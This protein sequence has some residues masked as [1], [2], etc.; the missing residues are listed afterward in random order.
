MNR[1]HFIK[2]FTKAAVA[3]TVLNGL[4]VTA[5]GK[6]NAILQKLAR[7]TAD[8]GRVLVMIE[9][10]GGN[11]G[12][13]TVVPIDQYANLS[14]AR[15]NLLIPENQ[16]LSLNGLAA[17]K[18]HPAMP[19]MSSL[20]NQELVNIVQGVGYPNPDYSHFRSTD[21]WLTGVSSDVY[22]D[23]GWMARYLDGLYPGF[24]QNYPNADMPDPLAIQ[25]GDAPSAALQGPVMNM[26]MAIL[27]PSIIYQFTTGTVDPA[28]ATPAGNE[29][30][31]IRFVAQQSQQYFQ[32]VR[33]AAL[34]ATN[35]STLYPPEGENK[36]A[37]ELKVVARLIAGG[38]KTPVY[39]TGL[40]GFD[41][42]SNQ[43]NVTGGST[44][45][46]H[47][48]LLRKVSQAIAAFQDDIHLL[49]IEDRVVG[50]TFSEFGRTITANGSNGTDHG[51]AAPM[52]VFGTQVQPRMIGTNPTI[53]PN[54]TPDDDVAMQHD[55]RQVYASVL[56]DW[57]QVDDATVEAILIGS[58]TT[59]PIFK[60]LVTTEMAVA[61]PFFRISP[62]PAKE[63]L[64]VQGLNRNTE[65]SI[66]TID[67][68]NVFTKR[69]EDT[70]IK[71]T[72]SPYS[73]GNYLVVVSENG[74]VVGTE[75][76]II[77]H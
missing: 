44:T 20:Y 4:P 37:D 53:I 18:L 38:L 62:N 2:E 45:G 11:D 75:K 19:E 16:L 7:Q 34:A 41:T 74:K 17:T 65:L 25:V 40:N 72:L 14:A 57:F 15:P 71:I 8:N 29:L 69:V 39:M 33:D 21:I 77:Q 23:T 13:N 35:L 54:A 48:E 49:G 60:P 3:A 22:S 51:T 66:Y 9:L 12:L 36:L 30:T 27:D 46:D 64:V 6:E 70:T 61:A 56:K 59:L 26:G 63:Y 52:F 68:K 42:H 43:I 50:M 55:Y 67:G 73:N 47:A 58:F 1:R 31:F 32:V 5:W 24:P 76:L 28:P 10:F